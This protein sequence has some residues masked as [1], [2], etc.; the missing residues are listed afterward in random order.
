MH[1]S[2]PADDHTLRYWLAVITGAAIGI[3]FGTWGYFIYEEW[4]TPPL[5]ALYH[6]VQLFEI[7]MPLIEGH[8]N[9]QL[10]LG[11]WA[12]AFSSGLA[13]LLILRSVF[14]TGWRLFRLQWTKN[15]VLVCGLGEVGTR[16][17][18][19]FKSSGKKVVA[20]ER[21]ETS[22][23]VAEV[24]S[25]GILVITGDAKAQDTLRKARAQFASKVLAVCSDDDTNIAI[26]VAVRDMAK[27]EKSAPENA[28]CLLLLADPGLHEKVA[29]HLTSGGG[30][31]EFKIKVGGFDM[32]DTVARLAFNEHPLDFDGIH[33]NDPVRVHLIVVGTCKLCEALV[34]KALQLCHFANRSRLRV[35]VVG[36]DAKGLIDRVRKR[37]PHAEPWYDADAVE[38]DPRDPEMPEKVAALPAQDEFV[39][40]AVCPS[41]EE[42]KNKDVESINVKTVIEIKDTL[43]EKGNKA[44]RSQILVYLRRRSGFGTLFESIGKSQDGVPIHAFGLIETLCNSNILLHETQDKLAR[45]MHEEYIREQDDKKKKAEAEGKKFIPR[46]AHTSWEKLAEE[47]RESNRMMADFL[48]IRLRAIGLR[49]DMPGKPDALISFPDPGDTLAKMEHER[50]CAEKWLEDYCYCVIRNDKENIHPDLKLWEELP[51]GERYIDKNFV[52]KTVSIVGRAEIAIY[53]ISP[54][55]G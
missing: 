53:P 18:L 36:H 7:H 54:K 30:A 17:A 2:Q 39:T 23:G 40:L 8:L 32:P 49:M 55:K 27:A 12:A 1:H 6:A 15:H 41:V 5:T 4:K 50:W 29:S 20:I 11:R 51:E 46:P 52:A 24:R 19:E 42:D 16:L 37:H 43:K 44:A 47:Y 9:W 26:T 25:H 28:E 33:E 14:L 48:A 22:P 35:S 34:V 13:I 45:E 31:G 38:C 10:E 3:F 21:T